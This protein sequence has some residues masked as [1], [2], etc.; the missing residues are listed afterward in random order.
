MRERQVGC[1]Q[2]SMSSTAATERAVAS[3]LAFFLFRSGFVRFLQILKKNNLWK[4]FF[5]V[6]PDVVLEYFLFL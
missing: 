4:L 5:V 3:G 6:N 2:Q 1:E